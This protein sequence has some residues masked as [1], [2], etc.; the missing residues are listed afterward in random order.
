VK[1]LT[2]NWSR[3]PPRHFVSA[4]LVFL[5]EAFPQFDF[6]CSG[7]GCVG[8]FHPDDGHVPCDMRHG[9]DCLEM[10]KI[11][12]SELELSQ[13]S[14]S[15]LYDEILIVAERI[16]SHTVFQEMSKYQRVKF[17]VNK[18]APEEFEE[19]FNCIIADI[20]TMLKNSS[21]KGGKEVNHEEVVSHEEIK[22]LSLK[23]DFAVVEFIKAS[24]FFFLREGKMNLS[25]LVSKINMLRWRVSQLTHSEE[26]F[27]KYSEE[28]SSLS[29][30]F[31][32]LYAKGPNTKH[33]LDDLQD[34]IKVAIAAKDERALW[35]LLPS[36]PLLENNSALNDFSSNVEDCLNYEGVKKLIHESLSRT[37]QQ[38]LP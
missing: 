13:D 21:H 29:L 26:K 36:G 10:N 20:D 23:A 9:N 1:V 7:R 25:K 6:V 12:E 2:Q 16:A 4:T 28:M 15:H 18:I 22:L 14:A 32:Y 37:R 17:I 35:I 11:V 38:Q 24:F 33:R 27:V 34:I 30:W 31:L 8:D 5:S 19:T 3:R